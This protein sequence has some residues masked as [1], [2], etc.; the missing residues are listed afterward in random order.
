V[1]RS[2][3]AS[4]KTVTDESLVLVNESLQLALLG[5]HGVKLVDIELAE[6]LDVDRTAILRV[7]RKRE[8]VSKRCKQVTVVVYST[9][10]ILW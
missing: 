1:A 10:S 3:R 2:I 4:R 8:R 7:F 5:G 9:L 6:P